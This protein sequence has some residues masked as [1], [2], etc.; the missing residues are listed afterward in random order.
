MLLIF[1]KNSKFYLTFTLA[2]KL[3]STH[4]KQIHA[5]EENMLPM[6]HIRLGPIVVTCDQYINTFM[7]SIEIL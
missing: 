6:T 4:P 7:Y 1:L 2:V 3:L 5:D